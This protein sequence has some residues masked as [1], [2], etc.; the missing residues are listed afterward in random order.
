M[1]FTRS[2]PVP[3]IKD[4]SGDSLSSFFTGIHTGSKTDDYP[5]RLPPIGSAILPYIQYQLGLV[6]FSRVTVRH[7]KWN[8]RYTLPMKCYTFLLISTHATVCW[9]SRHFHWQITLQTQCPLG[10]LPKI[11][12][13]S[14]QKPAR[15]QMMSPVQNSN[16]MVST[17]PKSAW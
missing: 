13:A 10:F 16:S 11:T 9:S 12:L 4:N 6:G 15:L 8:K 7:R 2:W 1:H 14:S 17:T 3:T 5:S